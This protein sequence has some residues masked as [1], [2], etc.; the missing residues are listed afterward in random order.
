MRDRRTL[1]HFCACSWERQHLI[2]EKLSKDKQ[3]EG[4]R[5]K[6]PPMPELK[7]QKSK[8]ERKK[9]GRKERNNESK[10]ERERDPRTRTRTRARAHAHAHR[11]RQAGRQTNSACFVCGLC[12][13]VTEKYVLP[14]CI[15]SA[16]GIAS[17]K[18]KWSQSAFFTGQ[19]LV[20]VTVGDALLVCAGWQ[21]FPSPPPSWAAVEE[22]PLSYHN[23]ETWYSL[24]IPIVW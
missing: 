23:K 21:N 7:N 2:R 6:E 15:A 3:R 24:N 18:L 16:G 4:G 9:E 12:Q 17:S 11:A 14:H 1:D 13:R 20:W 19:S 10:R 8:R 5:E 22:L